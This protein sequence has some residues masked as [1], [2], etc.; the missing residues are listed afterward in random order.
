MA[1]DHTNAATQ[2]LLQESRP[3]PHAIAN[4]HANETTAVTTSRDENNTHPPTRTEGKTLRIAAAMLSFSVMGLLVSTVGLMLPQLEAHYHLNDAQVSAIFTVAPLGYI[5]ATLLTRTVHARLGRRGIATLGPTLQLLGALGAGAHPSHYGVFLALL[6]IGSLGVGL[7]DGAW[8]AWAGAM[9]GNANTVSGLLHGS[10][11]VGAGLGPVLG[12]L[13]MEEGGWEWWAWY[14][15]LAGVTVLEAVVL[16]IAFRHDSAERY[17]AEQSHQSLQPS[18]HDNPDAEN[19]LLADPAAAVTINNV[20]DDTTPLL[21]PPNSSSLSSSPSPARAITTHPVV[22]I[23][24]AFL[25]V[26]VGTESAVSGWVVLFLSRARHAPPQLAAAGSSAFWIGQT[27]GRLSLGAV[28]DRYGLRRAVAVYLAIVAASSAAFAALPYGLESDGTRQLPGISVALVALMGVFCG[29]LFPS[30]IVRL[31]C[32]LP[33]A[34]HVGAVTYVAMIGQVGGA[35]LPVGIGLLIQSLGIG[36]FP[37]VV[38][39]QVVIALGLWFL[40]S[41]GMGDGEDKV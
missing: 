16:A 3:L 6:G 8:C 4:D 36:V 9:P 11:S 28:T 10:F 22:W 1:S 29:P 32:A 26:E 7:L 33:R 13:L 25:L 15:A 37:V 5:L 38:V 40:F 18:H 39:G 21:K 23:C 30:A 24:A 17:H 20:P 35:L 27:V 41:S 31:T 34:L 12:G 19:S 14:Y 2:P